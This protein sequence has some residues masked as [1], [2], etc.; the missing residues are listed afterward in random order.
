MKNDEEIK[1]DVQEYIF[2]TELPDAVSGVVKLDRRP[3]GSRK[4]DVIISI[5]ANE[6]GQIQDA[7]V[8]VNIYVADSP[9]GTQY[10]PNHERLKVLAALSSRIFEVFRGR[11]YRAKLLAQRI[12]AVA[13]HE[14][15]ITN[16]I[17]Y[18]QNNE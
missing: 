18:K 14:H 6:N 5:L 10:D 12:T 9:A 4:E 17:N 2:T 16:K 11:D 3:D 13:E 15:V 8:N 1:E 7:T